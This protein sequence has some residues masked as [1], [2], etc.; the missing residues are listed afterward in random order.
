MAMDYETVSPE[1]FGRSLSGVGLNLLTRDVGALAAFLS[2]VFG[3]RLYRASADFAI[4]AHGTALFQ[5]H[6]DATYRAHPLPGLLP[7]A[8]ARGA[9]A[10]IYLFGVNPDIAATRAEARGDPVPE[11]VADKPHGLRECT[12][13]S[14]E[15]D[16]F[17]PA[18]P[19]A[20]SR[21]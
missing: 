21:A 17:S 18:V 1:A 2:E 7:E 8:G 16:A 19:T 9:G 4:V 11:P 14:P 13:L 12:I 3:L 5:L 10:Q 20:Q 15:G 6:S